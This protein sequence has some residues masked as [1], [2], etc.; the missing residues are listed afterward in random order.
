MLPRGFGG[1]AGEARS[2]KQKSEV[3]PAVTYLSFQIGKSCLLLILM[4]GVEKSFNP[5]FLLKR[6]GGS[7]FAS[8][9][10]A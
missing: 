4:D 9:C 5:I 7:F 10:E 8:E 2:C 1:D 6:G 3:V